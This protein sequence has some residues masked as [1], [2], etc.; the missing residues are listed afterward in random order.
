MTWKSRLADPW[1]ARR[2]LARLDPVR[3]HERVTHLS[4]EVRYGDPVLTAALY[5]VA[6]ARQMA[7]PSIADVVHRGGRGPIIRRTRVR[8]DD[9]M[10]FFGI[11]MREGYSS[12]A[13]RAAIDRLNR[14]HA[15]FPITEEQSLYTLSS[16]VFEADRI[17]ALLGVRLLTDGEKT[18]NFH[19][20]RGVGHLMGITRIPDSYESFRQW[21]FDYEAANYGFTPGGR[22]VVDA[23]VDDFAARFAPPRLRPLAARALLAAM[24]DRLLDTHRLER[25]TPAARRA[26]GAA[27]ASYR[28]GR[29]LLPD[30]ADRS[31][32]DFYRGD[33]SSEPVATW[34]GLPADTTG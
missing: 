5:T 15:R 19:F 18:A 13:G 20:W 3:D 14:I 29:R 24:D 10:T 7:V 34:A 23:M 31:W 27:V 30:P 25:P 12:P 22:E 8:N 9:T 1:W 4:A 17:P 32:A 33:T 21:T 6:F 11:F 16:L 2:E 28:V 26:L